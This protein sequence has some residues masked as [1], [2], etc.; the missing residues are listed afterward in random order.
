VRAWIKKR[1]GLS[2]KLILLRGRD[3]AALYRRC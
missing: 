2:Q 3:L 1:G